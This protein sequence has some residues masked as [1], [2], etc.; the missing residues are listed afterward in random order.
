[1]D[2]NIPGVERITETSAQLV[3]YTGY[4]GG[5]QKRKKK[6]VEI[7]KKL[8]GDPAK[9]RDWL[10]AQRA[11]FAD[12]VNRGE[13]GNRTLT[14][15]AWADMWLKNYV[16][17]YRK[18]STIDFHSVN[19][20]RHIL[21]ELGGVKLENLSPVK[22][23]AFAKTLPEKSNG[24][25]GT[26][27]PVTVGDIKRTLAAM[28]ETAVEQ[29]MIPKNPAKLARW[30]K[31]ER[32]PGKA[33]TPDE[34]SVFFRELSSER[35]TWRALFLLMATTGMRRGEAVG[36]DWS[37]VDL[38]H[39]TIRIH[40]SAT[41]GSKGVEINTP[42]TH[43][44]KRSVAL[45]DDLVSMLGALRKQQLR[46]RMI[47]GGIWTD[48]G[49]VFCNEENGAR[50]HPGSATK[51][52]RAICDR[53]GV[54]IHLHGLRHSYVTAAL[55]AGVSLADI[56]RQVGHASTDVTARVY[57]HAFGDEISASRRISALV[58][59]ELFDNSG[60]ENSQ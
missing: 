13:V 44:G 14:V 22:I 52:F 58:Q 59:T 43:A 31:E 48:S 30:P 50:I 56:A 39:G 32:T 15:E 1:M 8:Q 29:E 28:L 47:C 19:L 27:S 51:R 57:A 53:C 2:L 33:A 21:P 37:D 16:I 17:P 41:S 46:T 24:R 7:P 55:H 11:K 12:Q 26:L 42:K 9:V 20:K 25:G 3:V 38:E 4:D 6:T 49:A 5:K 18:T 40:K 35:L 45:V 34:M 54:E 23:T 36:L 60:V 10:I